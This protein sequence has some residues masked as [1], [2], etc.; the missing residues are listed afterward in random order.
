MLA[1]TIPPLSATAAHINPNNGLETVWR[2]I[3]IKLIDTAMMNA[4]VEDT[5]LAGLLELLTARACELL[6]VDRCSVYLLD[7]DS[8]LRLGGGGHPRRWRGE[9]VGVRWPR[10]T[11]P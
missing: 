8:G 1:N 7:E 4:D 3:L 2:A 5:D 11:E 6:G 9:R 10:A